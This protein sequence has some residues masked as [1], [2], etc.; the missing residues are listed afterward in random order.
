MTIL[1]YDGRWTWVTNED[2]RQWTVLSGP[3]KGSSFMRNGL[4]RLGIIKAEVA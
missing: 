1:K 3:S 2:N 4:I